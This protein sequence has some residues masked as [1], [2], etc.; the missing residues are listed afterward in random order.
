MV[1]GPPIQRNDG[2]HDRCHDERQPE[3]GPAERR[4]HEL[5]HDSDHGCGAQTAEHGAVAARLSSPPRSHLRTRSTSPTSTGA[6]TGLTA[7]SHPSRS[8]TPSTSKPDRQTRHFHSPALKP[9]R[10]EPTGWSPE[11]PRCGPDEVPPLRAADGRLPGWPSPP[12]DAVVPPRAQRSTP[13]RTP[14]ALRCRRRRSVDR[15]RAP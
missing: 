2:D 6:M 10:T 1:P 15:R 14:P 12:V 3:P 9:N 8:T 7:T 13:A 5:R 4:G 11:L